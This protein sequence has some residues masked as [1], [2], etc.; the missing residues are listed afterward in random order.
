MHRQTQYPYEV[1][2]ETDFLYATRFAYEGLGLAVMDFLGVTTLVAGLACTATG[3]ASLNVNIGPGRIYSLQ[4]LEDTAWGILAG[5]GG[6]PVDTNADHKIIKQGLFRDTTAFPCAAPGTTGQ[7]IN[8]LIEASFSEVDANPVS[9]PFVSATPPYP[10]IAPA[11]LNT[12][13]KDSCVITVKAG[14]AATT[15]TQTTPSPDSGNVGLWVVTVANGQTTITSGN[16]SAYTPSSFIGE[17]LTQKISQASG[18][19]RYLQKA[20]ARVQLTAN[21]TFFVRSDGNDANTGLAN[22]AGGAFLTLQRASNVLANFYDFAGFQSSV[23][24]GAGTF[25]GADFNPC[26]GQISPILVVGQGSTTIFNT[27]LNVNKGG[28]ASFASLKT[29]GGANGIVSSGT[30][31]LAA[32]LEFGA[33]LAGGAQIYANGGT[34]NVTNSYTISGGAAAHYQCFNGAITIAGG[35]TVTLTGTPAFT[36][37]FAA[38]A[39]LANLTFTTSGGLATFSGSAT[40]PRYTANNLGLISSG[41]GATFLPGNSAGSVANGGVYS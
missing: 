1:P 38:S 40:G 41:G 13:R 3:P 29:S 17:T 10:P 32:G 6:L 37:A 33:T 9:L 5:V 31:T 11:T 2:A 14:V 24:V 21:T 30:A 12:V 4:N 34:I 7:S 26:V 8:Y 39:Q 22:T 18:D 16:I 27:Q 25:A 28:N 36:S 35:I 15:G 23:T 20:N 19:V